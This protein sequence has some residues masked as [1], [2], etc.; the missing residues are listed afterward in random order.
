MSQ[1]CKKSVERV[2]A[3]QARLEYHQH[4]QAQAQQWRQKYGYA[5][6]D[7]TVYALHFLAIAF[8][9]EPSLAKWA[10]SKQMKGGRKPSP[11]EMK[12]ILVKWLCEPC[13]YASRAKVYGAW[14]V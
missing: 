1:V 12:E 11:V 10:A 5:G 2:E 14:G 9:A 4:R 13:C 8:Q 3:A 7:D 6:D